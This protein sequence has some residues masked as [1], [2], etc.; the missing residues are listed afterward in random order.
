MYV[1]EDVAICNILEKIYVKAS[2]EQ[3]VARTR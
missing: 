3:Y 2:E 1:Y